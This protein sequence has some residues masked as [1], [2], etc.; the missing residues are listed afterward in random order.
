VV[1]CTTWPLTLLLHLGDGKLCD[2][3]KAGDVH[4]EDG[5]EV[6]LGVVGEWLGDENAGVVDV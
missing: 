5:S 2:V 1:I 6:G 4:A 3:E